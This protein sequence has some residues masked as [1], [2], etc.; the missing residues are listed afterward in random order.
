MSAAVEASPSHRDALLIQSN[1]GGSSPREHLE[2]G[3][4]SNAYTRTFGEV[5]STV[6]YGRDCSGRF[7]DITI[8]AT[9]P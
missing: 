5:S 9:F 8:D 6:Q 7:R 4:P 3:K 2:A 1:I